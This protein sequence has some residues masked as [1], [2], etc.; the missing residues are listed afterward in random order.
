MVPFQEF[1][2]KVEGILTS[3]EDL[4]PGSRTIYL[5]V[6]GYA[7]HTEM[8]NSVIQYDNSIGLVINFRDSSIITKVGLL[9]DKERLIELI[10]IDSF[11]PIV[12]KYEKVLALL[13]KKNMQEMGA[14]FESQVIHNNKIYIFTR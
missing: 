7:F 12:L 6:D 9:L 2:D 14:K 8:H 1:R 13:R 10:D 11:Q 3:K 5:P 4:L